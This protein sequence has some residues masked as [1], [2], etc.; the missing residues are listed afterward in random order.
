MSNVQA[1]LFAD[2]RPSTCVAHRRG[3]PVLSTGFPALDAVLPGGGWVRGELVE[4]LLPETSTGAMRL[5]TP[6]LAQL[7]V[8]QRWLS[9]VSPPSLP[10]VSALATAGVRLSCV[11]MVRPRSGQDGLAIVEKSLAQGQCSAVLA[12]PMLDDA[13]ILLRLRLAA[14]QGHALGFMFRRMD[15]ARQQ[16]PASLRLRLDTQ[17]HGNLAVSLLDSH[18]DALI[19]PVR[20]GGKPVLPASVKSLPRAFPRRRG[21]PVYAAS[22]LRT[23]S[24]Y[25]R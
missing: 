19:E 15:A 8:E 11:Q 3:A 9:W 7:S 18:G 13:A 14:R 22:P 2:D 10:S 21:R 25:C 6:A 20:I 12:W 1:Q 24:L 5:V 23:S 17:P 16:S 4:V